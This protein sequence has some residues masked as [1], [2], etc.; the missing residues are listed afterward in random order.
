LFRIGVVQPKDAD[1][2]RDADGT[3]AS[4]ILLVLEVGDANAPDW[5]DLPLSHLAIVVI[6]FDVA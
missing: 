2:G 4:E 6:Y 1:E 5:P 3:E